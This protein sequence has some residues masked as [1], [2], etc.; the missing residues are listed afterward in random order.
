MCITHRFA[1]RED[2]DT[3][4]RLRLAYLEED[5]GGL[6]P[7]ARSI[8]RQQL[9]SYFPRALGS[10]L[11]AV[12]AME[13]S[14]AVST[15][16]LVITEKPANLAFPT[17]KTGV[18]MNVY[19]L[20]AYRRRGLARRGMEMLIDEARRRGLSSLELSATEQG[21]PLYDALGFAVKK[22]AYTPMKL[23]LL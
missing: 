2:A 12:L 4:I 8:L 23:S 7:D 3:L 20:P 15:A 21:R 14:R 6:D 9:S 16:C 22:P 11:V 1:A 10:T 13:G 19:T 18:I 5:H 17:G